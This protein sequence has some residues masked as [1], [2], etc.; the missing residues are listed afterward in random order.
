MGLTLTHG[1]PSVATPAKRLES[2]KVSTLLF[3]DAS[4][5]IPRKFYAW[6]QLVATLVDSLSFRLTRAPM[7]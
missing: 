6:L 2:C 4:A 7:E 3:D 5:R 1:T